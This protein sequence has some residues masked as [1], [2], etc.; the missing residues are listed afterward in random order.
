MHHQLT[1]TAG[2][3]P[4][5]AA[6]LGRNRE[7]PGARGDH[8]DQGLGLGLPAAAG[9]VGGAS[10]QQRINVRTL[11]LLFALALLSTAVWLFVK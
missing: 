7:Q 8:A 10:L 3:G 11:E 2:L 1:R 6:H 4:H 9:A 5:A